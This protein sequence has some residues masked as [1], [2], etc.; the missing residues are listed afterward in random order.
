MSNLAELYRGLGSID[1]PMLT[2]PPHVHPYMA[3]SDDMSTE[4]RHTALAYKP[5]LLYLEPNDPGSAA[6]DSET[7]SSTNPPPVTGRVLR[8]SG[9]ELESLKAHATD[10]NSG[11]WVTTFEALCALF[12][13]CIYQ[14]RL[15]YQKQTQCT[16]SPPDFLTPVN[17]LSTSRGIPDLPPTYF[18]NN[19]LCAYSA[20]SHDV[21]AEGPLWQIAKQLYD[22]TRSGFPTADEVKQTIQWI[23]AHPD[24][25]QIRP[26]FRYG[27]GSLMISSWAKFDMYAGTEFEAGEKP[28]LVVPPFTP[29]SLLDGLGYVLPTEMHGQKTGGDKGA[30][31][32]YIALSE[33]L[34][35]ILERDEQLGRF[36][37]EWSNTARS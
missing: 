2:R 36:S 17:I 32:V 3:N 37:S 24:K 11:S 1:V 15:H 13:Q 22:M 25:H 18:P 10:P 7:T 35:E 29:I 12:H 31:D 14:A 5:S 23:A 27:N 26:G 28:A 9:S 8:F 16:L 20:F 21:L 33:P 6:S 4:E 30:L 19:L 34:W